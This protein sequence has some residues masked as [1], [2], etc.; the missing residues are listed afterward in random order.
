MGMVHLHRHGEFSVLDGMGSA[1]EYAVRAAELGMRALALT[2]H[3]TLGGALHH[4]QACEEHGIF[5]IVGCE[6]YFKPNR[7]PQNA[8]NRAYYHMVLLAKDLKGW[9]NLLRLTSDSYRDDSYYYKPIVDCYMLQEYSEGLMAST[10]C[11]SSYLSKAILEED[12]NKAVLHLDFMQSLFGSDFYVEIM[13]NTIPEQRRINQEVVYLANQRGI[14]VVATTDAHYPCEALASTHHIITENVYENDDSTLFLMTDE[15]VHSHF[16]R[17]HDGLG[18][19]VVQEAIDNTQWVVSQC[20][21]YYLDKHPKYPRV[22][23]G[24][25]AALKILREWCE[26]VLSRLTTPEPYRERMEYELEVFQKNGVLDYFVIVGDLVRWAMANEVEVGPGRGSAAGSVVSY[27]I[28]ITAVDPLAHGLLF[29]R[30]LNPDRK[31]MPDIDLDFDSEGRERAKAYLKE[32]YGEN[33]VADIITYQT[34]GPKG[35]IKKVARSLK[36]NYLATEKLSES[37]G[38]DLSATLESLILVNENLAEW[39]EENPEAWQHAL[40]MEGQTYAESKHAAGVVVTDRPIQDNM[41]TM[42]AKDGSMTTAWSDSADFPIISMYGFLK[43]DLLGLAAMSR[44]KAATNLINQRYSTDYDFNYYPLP[45]AKDPSAGEPEVLELLQRD[46]VGVFQA[47]TPGI[48][49]VLKEMKCDHFNDIAAAVALYRPGTMANIPTYCARKLGYEKVTYAHADLE[50][51]LSETYGLYV[52]QE[53]A[54]EISKR[55][56]GFTGG[57][58]DD[59][60]KAIGKKLKELMESLRE[61]FFQGARDNSYSDDLA[62]SLWG[63]MEASADYSFNKSHAVC[64]AVNAYTDEW[65][66]HHYPEEFYVSLL[67][68]LTKSTKKEKAPRVI[69]AIQARGIPLLPPD[70]NL[71]GPD[72]TIGTEGEIRFGLQSVAQVG[73]TA[74]NEIMTKRPYFSVEDVMANCRKSK[75]NARHIKHLTECGAFDV[76]GARAGWDQ[77][78]CIRL[79]REHIG[80]ALSGGMEEYN[81]VLRDRVWNRS[82][83]DDVDEEEWVVVGGEVTAFKHHTDKKGKLMAFV[84]IAYG[85]DSFNLTFF[86]KILPKFE[87]ML[88]VGEYIIVG[89]RK[90]RNG[91]AVMDCDLVSNVIEQLSQEQK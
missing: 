23:G 60:R 76:F 50:D 47:E 36:M 82:E 89:G 22:K 20:S 10:A 88:T 2:D 7:A 24:E 17:Y 21:P 56:A 70:I 79:E 31:G 29:E 25:G 45:V 77:K 69:R 87:S 75:V 8:E 19:R 71:S 46:T 78:D 3:G 4:V 52:Y 5:P 62:S 11:M 43:M 34:Y 51:I 54:M 39:A 32:K 84:D 13:P 58:A 41:P 55:I 9:Q 44:R 61:R 81:A 33:N 67:S 83:F 37:L 90:S 86:S 42:R 14:P 18:E 59:L 27:L 72:F 16:R 49:R 6:V 80:F 26:G 57:E 48:S 28:G 66:K 40:V 65:L 85:A 38:D 64:Y 15:E 30:F 1:E 74:C 63:Q 53:Q 91:V 73:V 35:A 12:D 68:T